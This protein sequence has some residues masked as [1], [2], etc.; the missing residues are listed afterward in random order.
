MKTNALGLP[1]L[2]V[3]FLIRALLYTKVKG[4]FCLAIYFLFHKGDGKFYF[5]SPHNRL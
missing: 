1:T 4:A 5:F 2:A 3:S